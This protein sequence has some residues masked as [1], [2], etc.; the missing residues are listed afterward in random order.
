MTYE[1]FK[2]MDKIDKIRII[3]E[4]IIKFFFILFVILIIG[5][6]CVVAMAFELISFWGWIYS[7]IF[8]G[9]LKVLTLIEKKYNF[10]PPLQ[11]LNKIIKLFFIIYIIWSLI[12]LFVNF[13][14]R[15]F[16]Y[17]IWDYLGLSQ[18]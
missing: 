10:Y 7:G 8:A 12:F 14:P 1:N 13:F 6:L 16:H 9:I 17:F 5:I 3:V 11:K 2:E 18:Q 4:K 15:E